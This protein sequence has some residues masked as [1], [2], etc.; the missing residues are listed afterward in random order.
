MC[1]PG[2]CGGAEEELGPLELELLIAVSG[3]QGLE[4]EPGSSGRAISNHLSSPALF[5]LNR[6]SDRVSRKMPIS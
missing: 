2:A 6:V 4:I 5:F 1:M 3:S